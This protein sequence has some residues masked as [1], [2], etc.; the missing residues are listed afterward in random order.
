MTDGEPTGLREERVGRVGVLTLDRPEVRNAL[1][2][3]LLGAMQHALD[4]LASDDDVGAVVLTGA[5]DRAFCS[6]MDLKAF[7]ASTPG[8]E[9]GFRVEPGD[10]VLP[11][12]YPKPM[13]AAVNGAAVAGGFE[14][15]LACDLVVASVDATFGLAEVQRGLIAAGGGTMLATRIPLA[16]AL[17][18]TLLGER[19]TASRAYELGL[20]N[21]LVT[22]DAVLDT[23]LELADRLAGNGPLAMRLT[24][25]LV[26]GAVDA[27]PDRGRPSRAEI[28]E[29]FASADAQEGALAFVE[30]REPRWT[31]R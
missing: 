15:V 20:V 26:R 11:W 31:G 24:K 28:E 14:L 17:E 4:D 23:A 12:D 27:G 10:P 9:V 5:G 22:A 25:R 30:K 29:I 18:I 3:A 7:A 6:G 13:V 19:I 1:S 2:P 21:R 16:A 8:D